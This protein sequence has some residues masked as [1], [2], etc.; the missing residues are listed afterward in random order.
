MTDYS[1]TK[2]YKIESTLGDK[3]YVGST[4]KLY[5]SQRFQQHKN[6]FKRWK[7]GK[8]NKTTSFDLFDEYGQ[9]SCNIILLESYPCSTKDEK[10]A[11][12]AHYIKELNCVNKIIPGRTRKEYRVDN[13]EK[14][15][16]KDKNYNLI[17]EEKIKKYQ[18]EY[19]EKKKALKKQQQE[20]NINDVLIV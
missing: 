15:Q 3:V 4:C 10:N 6:D 8:R 18:K 17:N 5:L 9:E 2:I 16:I 1:K 14:I 12:E 19:R 13:K 20:E 11:R 7:D